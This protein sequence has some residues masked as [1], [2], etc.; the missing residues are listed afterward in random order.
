M[1]KNLLSPYDCV[2]PLVI[3]THKEDGDNDYSNMDF[4]I[5][6]ITSSWEEIFVFVSVFV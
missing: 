6:L 2:L 3:F 1:C 4:E 5:T